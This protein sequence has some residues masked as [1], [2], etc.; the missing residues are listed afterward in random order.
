MG[1]WTVTCACSATEVA[2]ETA[3]AHVT[4]CCVAP[5]DEM[6]HVVDSDPPFD[7]QATA[8]RNTTRHVRRSITTQRQA[9]GDPPSSRGGEP[10][11]HPRP[12]ASQGLT[13]PVA[14][15]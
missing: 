14:E 11:L 3:L 12:S 4:T 1:S 7:V 10:R 6:T 5:G 13:R 15:P 8:R 9:L 2:A